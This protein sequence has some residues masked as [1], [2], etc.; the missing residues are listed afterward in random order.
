MIL[1]AVTGDDSSS[2]LRLSSTRGMAYILMAYIVMAYIFMAYMVMADIVR[3]VTGDNS[4]SAFGLVTR[5]R[6][7]TKQ[8]KIV[9]RPTI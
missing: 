3:A 6:K 9:Y 1:R 7:F 2:A 5:L 4:S 8:A